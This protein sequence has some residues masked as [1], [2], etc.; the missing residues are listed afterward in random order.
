MLIEIDDTLEEV[1]KNVR[2]EIRRATL[3]KK[4]P[5]RFVVLGTQSHLIAMRYVVLRKVDE[6]FNLLLYTDYRSRK[7]NELI[8]VPKAQLLFYHPQK[9][10]QV[11]VTC[12]ATVHRGDE[13][14]KTHWQNV[15]GDGKKAYCSLK[16]PGEPVAAP[17]DAFD[18][19]EDFTSGYFTVLSMKPTQI[20]VLQLRGL[21]HL[22]AIFE[23]QTDWKGQWVV[24]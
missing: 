1:L 3:D 18:W 16:A 21:E 19:D 9:K 14:A 10:I 13:I 12:E 22:R 4:H 24:P 5:F 8:E 23:E 11:V 7:V 15:Q 17:E 20:E 6:Q 2:H